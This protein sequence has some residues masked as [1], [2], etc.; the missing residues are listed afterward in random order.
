MVSA[1]KRCH[2]APWNFSGVNLGGVLMEFG[3]FPQTWRQLSNHS[4]RGRSR[5]PHPRV[6]RWTEQRISQPAQLRHATARKKLHMMIKR[7]NDIN[8]ETTG[9]LIHLIELL[10]SWMLSQVDVDCFDRSHCVVVNA[11]PSDRTRVYHLKHITHC[12]KYRSHCP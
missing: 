6:I 11:R 10:R 4:T 7:T 12:V 9:E 5:I 1:R 3:G 8:L 2:V